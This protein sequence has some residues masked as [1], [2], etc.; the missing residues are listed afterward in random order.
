MKYLRYPLTE[1]QVCD[2]LNK[3]VLSGNQ[4]N[5]PNLI[6]KLNCETRL[7]PKCSVVFTLM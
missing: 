1:H 2:Y 4:A 6:S 7:T 5:Y 3:F